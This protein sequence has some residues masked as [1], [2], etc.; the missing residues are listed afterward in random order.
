LVRKPE[1][2]RILRRSRHRPVENIKI[3]LK[4]TMERLNLIKVA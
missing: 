4:Q 1:G 2:K 3:H